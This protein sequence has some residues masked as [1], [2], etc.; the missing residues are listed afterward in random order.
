MMGQRLEWVTGGGGGANARRRLKK[1]EQAKRKSQFR[2]ESSASA[3][4]SCEYNIRAFCSLCRFHSVTLAVRA[5]FPY[6]FYLIVCWECPL[7]T[8]RLTSQAISC[9]TTKDEKKQA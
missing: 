7:V 1:V 4:V 2:F 3:C 9:D 6:V 5:H 8:L